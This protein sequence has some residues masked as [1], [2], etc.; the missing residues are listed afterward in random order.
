MLLIYIV[1][2]TIDK[3]THIYIM[4]YFIRVLQLQVSNME[5]T[6]MS[7]TGASTGDA[8]IEIVCAFAIF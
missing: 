7:L 6:M 1:I 4:F 8:T 2:Y 5:N 3:R